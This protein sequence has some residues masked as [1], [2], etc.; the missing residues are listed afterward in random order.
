MNKKFKTLIDKIFN[1]YDKYMVNRQYKNRSFES[2]ED[3]D[4]QQE[5][6]SIEIKAIEKIA[7]AEFQNVIS[8]VFPHVEIIA[9]DSRFIRK[10]KGK[11]GNVLCKG[12]TD[13]E[14]ARTVQG[15][16]EGETYFSILIQRFEDLDEE[17]Q[18]NFL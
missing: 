1:L 8:E 14:E 17:T 18:K 6:L 12:L 5:Q 4:K 15:Y 10:D 16:F 11:F 2:I 9:Y 13:L 7:I 3:Y